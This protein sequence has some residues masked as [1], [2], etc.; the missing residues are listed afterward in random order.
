[1][2]AMKVGGMKVAAKPKKKSVLI[3]DKKVDGMKVAM[4][5]MKANDKSSMPPMKSKAMPA[6][7]GTAGGALKRPAAA[8]QDAERMTEKVARQHGLDHVQI[9]AYGRRKFGDMMKTALAN[10]AKNKVVDVPEE[11]MDE[12]EQLCDPKQAHA[13]KYGALAL[14]RKAWKRDPT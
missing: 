8:G 4:K 2:K 13:G 11:I 7:T 1:M 5:A 6:A 3:G 10:R 9:T 14:L 12:Y